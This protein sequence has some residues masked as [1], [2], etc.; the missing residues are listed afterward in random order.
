MTEY[1]RGCDTSIICFYRDLNKG[2]CPCTNCLVKV[3]CNDQKDFNECD[4]FQKAGK[5]MLAEITERGKKR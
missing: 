1:C 4:L 3:I 2:D 5:M